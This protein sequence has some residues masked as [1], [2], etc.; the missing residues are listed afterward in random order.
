MD[1]KFTREDTKHAWYDEPGGLHPFDR[2]TVPTRNNTVDMAGKCRSPEV[3]GQRS[4]GQACD[5]RIYAQAGHA[6][7]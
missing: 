4:N 7:R 2:A 3:R 1:Q 6:S 5:W